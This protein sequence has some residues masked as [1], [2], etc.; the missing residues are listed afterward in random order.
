[1]TACSTKKVICIFICDVSIVLKLLV[2]C[3]LVLQLS[4]V[5]PSIQISN[6]TVGPSYCDQGCAGNPKHYSFMA[7]MSL[8]AATMLVQLSHLIKLVL[9]VLVVTAEGVVNIYSWRDIYD[10]YDYMQ[11]GPYR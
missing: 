4:C 1:M 9:M 3:V 8:I 11:F 6:G 5:P 7:V 10:V 2:L